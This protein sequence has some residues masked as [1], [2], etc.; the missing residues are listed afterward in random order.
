LKNSG[1]GGYA[2]SNDMIIL[3][4]QAEFDYYWNPGGCWDFGGWGI[5]SYQD[6]YATNLGIQTKAIKKMVD[7]LS[8]P[9]D[10]SYSVSYNM[11]NY[12]AQDRGGPPSDNQRES[13]REFSFSAFASFPLTFWL[14]F[15]KI[16][17]LVPFLL[18][19]FAYKVYIEYIFVDIFKFLFYWD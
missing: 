10:T 19:R 18:S 5:P 9:L 7:H 3:F 16:L 14:N 4:P 6:R 17:A 13:D 2:S 11:F 15:A 12:V 8:Q 1:F